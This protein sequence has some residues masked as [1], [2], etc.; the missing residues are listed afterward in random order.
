AALASK[1]KD[2]SQGESFFADMT[3]PYQLDLSDGLRFSFSDGEIVH[4]RPSGNAPELRLYIEA[5]T[6]IRTSELTD[7]IA[8]RLEET[9]SDLG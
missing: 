3:L 1:L 9:L 8:A 2:A 5:A 7:K 4:I 6:A